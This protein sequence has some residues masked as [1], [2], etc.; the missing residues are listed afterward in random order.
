MIEIVY[1]R[2][3]PRLTLRGHAGEGVPGRDIVCADIYRW[4]EH[5]VPTAATV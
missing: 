4:L 5:R 1:D 3:E 2:S